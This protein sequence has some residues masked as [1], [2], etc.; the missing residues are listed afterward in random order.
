MYD[1]VY[2][3]SYTPRLQRKFKKILRNNK[4]IHYSKN[5]HSVPQR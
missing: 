5:L 1:Y 4:Y 3:F 2:K